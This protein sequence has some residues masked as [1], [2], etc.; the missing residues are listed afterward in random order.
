MYDIYWDHNTIIGI[1]N[2]S[3]EYIER[4]FLKWKDSIIPPSP[5]K[6]DKRV[7][8]YVDDYL[9]GAT[10]AIPIIWDALKG[11]GNVNQMVKTENGLE[12]LIVKA[13]RNNAFLLVQAL[14]AAG[15]NLNATDSNG[16]TALAHAARNNALDTTSY[17]LEAGADPMKANKGGFDPLYLAEE[18]KAPEVARLL[19]SRIAFSD[20]AVKPAAAAAAAKPAAAAAAPEAVCKPGAKHSGPAGCA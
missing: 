16:F 9:Y 13:A 11:G 17:L 19:K 18:A 12:P 3:V 14:A 20:N 1:K 4:P 6:L 8:N 10:A 2:M 7:A 5:A 15:A